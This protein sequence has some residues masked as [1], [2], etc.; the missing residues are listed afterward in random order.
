MKRMKN[1]PALIVCFLAWR[2][3]SGQNVDQNTAA[4]MAIGQKVTVRTAHEFMPE[5]WYSANLVV[6]RSYCAELGNVESPSYAGRSGGPVISIYGTNVATFIV[7]S[8]RTI[9]E[10]KGVYARAC[11]IQPAAGGSKAFARV[12]LDEGGELMTLRW[13]ETTMF[14][15][16]FFVAGDYNAFSLIRNTTGQAQ[17][18]VHVTWHGLNGAVAGTT[19]LSIPANGTAI[20]NARDF[21]NPALFSNGSVEIAHFGSAQALVGST[22]TLSA[23]T[24][25]GFD[26]K[27]VQRTAW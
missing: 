26:A 1:F 22:T 20:L 21:V 14:C 27:F 12:V 4:A 6:G 10:P 18:N 3:C 8:D 17:N 9:D 25:L 2:V 7:S 15:P 23:K 16:W 13:I 19:T 24:G 11:W 5:S